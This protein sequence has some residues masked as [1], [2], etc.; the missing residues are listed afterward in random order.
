MA[1]AA[2]LGALV[3]SL[4]R[5]GPDWPAQEFRA[6]SAAHHGL[7]VITTRWYEGLPLPG[8]SVLY[9]PLA[10]VFGAGGV[11]LAACVLITVGAAGIAPPASR[12][13]A[14]AVDVAVALSA[15]QSLVIGQVPFLLGAACGVWALR[16]TLTTRRPVTV[17][18]LALLASLASPLAGAF[19][20]LVIPAL[21]VG[22]G[23]RAT[24][25]LA[26]AVGGIVAA[27]V[28]GGASGPF[29]CPWPS[30]VGVVAFA[31]ALLVFAPAD[32]R[33]MRV[34]A[35]C[36]LVCAV[37]AF[38]VPN[39]VGGNITRLGKLLA[40]PLACRYLGFWPAR[41]RLPA[42]VVAL[43]AI[44]WPTVPFATSAANGATD[45]SGHRQF[46]TGLLGYL[47]QH[48]AAGTRLEIPFTRDHWEAYFVAQAFPIAR[49]WERQSDLRYNAALYE[50]I[51][52]PA[53]HRWLQQNAVDFVALPDVP[54][55]SGGRAESA[56]LQHPPSYLQPVWHDAHW[57]LWRVRDPVPMVTG[58]AVIDRLTPSSVR[59]RF[60]G[61]GQAVV[62]L[63]ATSLWQTSAHG[64]CV[65]TDTA[66]WL[67]VS[68][69]GP[70]T[71]LVTAGLNKALLRGT[72]C[73]R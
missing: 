4:A 31:A 54:L 11:G 33:A 35:L 40:I 50:P 20:L 57:Q 49:G 72:T 65:G 17:A 13:R 38:M 70:R 62:R 60:T 68:S 41:L 9:P 7:G 28:L 19:V 53:Y 37:L 66:G 55:D 10:A 34:F 45:P 3:V 44:A 67:T 56:L 64:V 18:A 46:Y 32:Q 14:L 24:L 26:A 73:D 47:D 48:A 27:A 39:P 5:W 63:R 51:S 69:T 43:V 15:L 12:R 29:P 16:V 30:L 23:L 25:P 52:A 59:L 42:A 58:P 6:W 8:Y 1:V 36:Y 22:K 2:L 21:F 71:V 61:A